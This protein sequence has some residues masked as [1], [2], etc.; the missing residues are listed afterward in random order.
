MS[1]DAAAVAPHLYKVLLENERV[2]VLELRGRP[3]DRADLHSHPGQV[4][5]AI[6]DSRLRFTS[7]DGQSTEAE[8]KSGQAVYSD[9]VEHTTEVAGDEGAHVLLV[10]LK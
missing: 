8:L 4:V 3:G 1:G 9:A 6:S 2:R 5:I 10:E 7:P